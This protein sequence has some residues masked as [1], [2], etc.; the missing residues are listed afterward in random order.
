MARH[1]RIMMD[2]LSRTPPEP[3]A[4]LPRDGITL[5]DRIADF[6][7]R[8]RR[9]RKISFRQM[10]RECQTRVEVILSFL[11]V[12]ELLRTGECDA[13]QSGAWGD[14]EVVAMEPAGVA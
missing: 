4:M 13:R 6:R 7:E 11:A 9:G 12:L 1:A 14:I 3:K 10:I 5:S 8:L 2:V